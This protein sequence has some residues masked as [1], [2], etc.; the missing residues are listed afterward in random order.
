[1]AKSFGYFCK[2]VEVLG[3]E[4]RLPFIISPSMKRIFLIGAFQYLK[5]TYKKD[6]EILFTRI[7]SDSDIKWLESLKI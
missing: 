4:S 5:E 7:F 2:E 6:G 1:M 3:Q